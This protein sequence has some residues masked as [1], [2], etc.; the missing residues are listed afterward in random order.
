MVAKL[1]AIPVLMLLMLGVLLGC[2]GASGA[3]SPTAGGQ[4]VTPVSSIARPT[5][6]GTSEASMPFPSV[7]GS[8][9]CAGG[10]TDGRTCLTTTV[11][12]FPGGV[13]RV[14]ETAVDLQTGE[15]L[16]VR[17]RGPAPCPTPVTTRGPVSGGQTR[18]GSEA[19]DTPRL[20]T[21]LTVVRPVDGAPAEGIAC[22]WADLRVV[23]PLPTVA[24]ALSQGQSSVVVMLDRLPA[25]QATVEGEVV[26]QTGARRRLTLRL[27]PAG[28]VTVTVAGQL[29]VRLP[30]AR[31]VVVPL[32]AGVMDLRAV[33][34]APYRLRVRVETPDGTVREAVEDGRAIAGRLPDLLIDDCE[35]EA[36]CLLAPT[37]LVR[38]LLGPGESRLVPATAVPPWP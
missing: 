16:Y 10:V 23:V 19:T 35:G 4:T 24:L 18:S 14:L 15:V 11:A 9:V 38:P 20:C 33:V 1:R 6:F 17:E 34:R 8:P 21:T 37:I 32:P 13:C 2:G 26:P 30:P 31:P 5:A 3:P 7:E 29:P 22:A 25:P 36:A 27:E 28:P 12:P